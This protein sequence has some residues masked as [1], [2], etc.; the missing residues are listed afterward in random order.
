M[1][2]DTENQQVQ[3]RLL[4]RNYQLKLS[5]SCYNKFKQTVYSFLDK[6]S[7]IPLD[8][9]NDEECYSYL[10]TAMKIGLIYIYR[11]TTSKV[12]PYLQGLLESNYDN[13]YTIIDELQSGYFSLKG[14][15]DN[16]IY[17][18][19]EENG[20]MRGTNEATIYFN[21]EISH[22]PQD[23]LCVIEMKSAGLAIFNKAEHLEVEKICSEF[24]KNNNTNSS[25]LGEKIFPIHIFLAFI[26]N[27]LQISNNIFKFVNSDG[28]ID[29]IL[30]T[31]Y[32]RR[33]HSYYQRNDKESLVGLQ[34]ISKFEQ[35]IKRKFLSNLSFNDVRFSEKNQYS[36]S[37]YRVSLIGDS[38]KE[39]AH[40]LGAGDNYVKA[41]ERGIR[42][43][44]GEVLKESGDR[45]LW[46]SDLDKQM[47]Y[48]RAMLHFIPEESV[49]MYYLEDLEQEAQALKEH[50]EE[51]TGAS[52][53]VIIR[54]VLNE[55]A[56]W[57]MIVDQNKRITY[58]S[59]ASL[60]LADEIA[61]GFN[62]ILLNKIN[63]HNTSGC[64]RIAAEPEGSRSLSDFEELD[65]DA[66]YDRL[67]LFLGNRNIK[68]S[69][70][71]YET[72]FDDIG[73]YVGKFTE[74][75]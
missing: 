21:D 73:M 7:E 27:K 25:A 60:N 51:L 35:I 40:Y 16:S 48:T 24:L 18:F 56:G 3:I 61:L 70:W 22:A 50:V 15:K 74:E 1:K 17:E 65:A 30:P 45:E 72:A 71:L 8:W 31:E 11:S 66:F 5:E 47:Y 6:P 20:L 32:F 44:I 23:S 19:F 49:Y 39:L 42:Y 26:E 41:A 38:E 52:Y 29:E 68:E 43:G 58:K 53:R 62:K 36:V 64:E 33:T 9:E 59:L 37:Q 14:L 55:V 12:S 57:I 67:R 54:S 69:I 13:F 34:L 4:K 10:K 63:G 75:E 2:Y 46:I 28:S